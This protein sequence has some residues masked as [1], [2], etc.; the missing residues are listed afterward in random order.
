VVSRLTIVRTT[1]SRL[2]GDSQLDCYLRRHCCHLCVCVCV[3]VCVCVC[4]CVRVCVCVCVCV[5]ACVCVC[6]CVC[7]CDR[8]VELNPWH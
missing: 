3:R 5:C 6:V 7:V 4:V 1:A 8:N 2:G